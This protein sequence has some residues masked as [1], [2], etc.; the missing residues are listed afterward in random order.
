[1][2]EEVS[3]ATSGGADDRPGCPTDRAAL[4]QRKTT[5][6]HK[7]AGRPV[8]RGANGTWHVRGHPQARAVLRS[9][10]TKQAG[11]NAELLE[12]LPQRMRPPILYQEGQPH[13]EQR[14]GTARFFSPKTV[15]ESYRDLMEELAGAAIR[16]LL[17]KRR[18]DLDALS[19]ELA[20]GVAAQVVGLTES[21]LPGMARRLDAFF[22]GDVTGFGWNPRAILGFARNQARVAAFFYLDVKPAIEARKKE[23]R[24][25]VIS[26]LISLGYGPAEILTECI[27]YGAAGMATTREFIGIAAWHML[28]QPAL[29]ERYLSSDEGKRHDVLGEILR[30]EPVVGRLYRRATADLHLKDGGERVTIPRG[31]LIA[32]DTYAINA[33]ETAVGEC[34]LALTPGRELVAERVGPAVMSF[35]DGHHRCP[36]YYV[37]LQETDV[38]LT[39]LLSLENLR[40]ERKPSVSWNDLIAGYE[41]R[42]FTVALV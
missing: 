23:P 18:A 2:S 38:F 29:R 10:D 40:I 5:R 1:M 8:E 7:P 41:L 25:D 35:G 34:P 42:G 20:V 6:S 21:R 16:R 3:R 4:S 17:R 12:G 13:H 22:E 26:H 33:D 9:A 19:M 36:G 11:F 28:E 37:A 14:R 32:L 31:S 15:S 24:E 39:R 30:L 27:T